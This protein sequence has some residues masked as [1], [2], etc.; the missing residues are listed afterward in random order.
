MRTWHIQGA[1]HVVATDYSIKIKTLFFLI[2]Q[3]EVVRDLVDGE[4]GLVSNC[5]TPGSA[6]VVKVKCGRL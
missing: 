2:V 5:G 1:Q 3:R 6:P 4:G